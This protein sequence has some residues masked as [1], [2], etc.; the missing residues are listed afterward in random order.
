MLLVLSERTTNMEFKGIKLTDILFTFLLVA[1]FAF[2]LFAV[3][4]TAYMHPKALLCLL[5]AYIV[6]EGLKS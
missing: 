4:A 6:Y 1:G 3:M 5:L 2:V